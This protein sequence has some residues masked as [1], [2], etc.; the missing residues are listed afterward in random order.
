M[1]QM[2]VKS[3]VAQGNFKAFQVERIAQLLSEGA[4]IPFIARYRKEM[5]GNLDEVE[6]R[7]IQ[8]DL[9]KAEKFFKRKATILEKLEELEVLNNALKDKIEACGDIDELESI[10]A[11]FKAGKKT[12]AQKARE[13]GLEPLAKMIMSQKAQDLHDL[14]F[15]FIK[16]PFEDE[17]AV[18]DAVRYIIIEWIQT[19]LEL[20]KQ[21]KEQMT[22]H[23]KFN[24]KKVRGKSDE[25]LEKY[26]DYI[27]FTQLWSK[28]PAHRVLA[29]ERANKEGLLNYKIESD[30]TFALRK[31]ERFYLKGFCHYID[32]LNGV[33]DEAYSKY[34]QPSL[35]T[36]LWNVMKDKADKTSIEIFQQ[37][38]TQLLMQAPVG[39]HRVLGID[40]GFRTGCKL[41]CI[42]EY[43]Q[44]LNNDNVYPH[45]PQREDK[46][47]I[48]KIATLCEQ[49]KIEVIAIGDGTASRETEALIKRITFK[50]P[51]KVFVISEAGASVYSASDIGRKEFPKYDVTVRGAVSIARRILD[52]MSELVKIDPKSIGVG[53]YQHEVNQKALEE[54]LDFQVT[55]VVNKVGV[56]LN[57]A[58][59][60]LLQYVAGLSLNMAEK[61]VA[62][63]DEN[64]PYKS[65]KDLLNVPRLGAKVFEQAAGFIRIKEGAD[66]L[67]DTGIHPERYKALNQWK[68][69]HKIDWEG[70]LG[71]ADAIKDLPWE[72]LLD[73]EIGAATLEDIKQEIA[74]PGRDIRFK[75]R[76]FEF[77]DIHE[78]K[79]VYEGM[80]LPGIVNNITHFGAFVN[81]GIK[82]NGLIHISEITDKFI[83]N[84]MEVLKLGQQVHVK[85]LEVDF[86]RKR[87][88]LS[89]KQVP[90]G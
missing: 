52:P 63:R 89:M 39:K 83:E 71:N 73:E 15:N 84:P 40:P 77:A 43:G 20:R 10:Y 18:L 44:L 69:K 8:S 66:P 61:V 46:E 45:A 24:V 5:T 4:T 38:L 14:C 6:I 32:W 50:N 76:A 16:G 82:E 26:R 19:N 88:G 54:G 42:D 36:E 62:Y 64:G 78:L 58:S 57:T 21:L 23:A 79:D 55:S 11:P 12:K 74:K 31:I 41:V 47:A 1:D 25:E 80:I 17:K 56:N 86:T 59:A 29:V 60:Y 67:D 85:V 49:Y 30:K 33:F 53:Q 87:I 48:R 3:V 34:I 81:I 51:P 28:V 2:I 37:N 35:Q 22:Q 72:E 13:A 7:Q 90:K 27:D 70:V 75:A 65:K 9:E 68:K